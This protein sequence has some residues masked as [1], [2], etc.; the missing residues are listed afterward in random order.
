MKMT[1]A[2]SSDMKQ[3]LK[4]LYRNFIHYFESYFTDTFFLIFSVV[5][6]CCQNREEQGSKKT[7]PNYENNTK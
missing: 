6:P 3:F 5:L 2:F 4:G 1:K 7:H